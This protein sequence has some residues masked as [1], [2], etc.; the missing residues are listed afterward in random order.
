MARDLGVCGI[1]R[2]PDGPARQACGQLIALPHRI[3]QRAE[4]GLQGT[5]VFQ[6]SRHVADAHQPLSL[7]RGCHQDAVEAADRWQGS[8]AREPRPQAGRRGCGIHPDRGQI[9]PFDKRGQRRL[10]P[11]G[12]QRRGGPVQLHERLLRHACQTRAGDM[13]VS[14]RIGLTG[15]QNRQPGAGLFQGL[16][17]FGRGGRVG[18]RRGMK[19]KGFGQSPSSSVDEA[20]ASSS[21]SRCRCAM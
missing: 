2:H 12:Q 11:P 8:A 4:R 14:A 5:K 9:V 10:E 19:P 17:Q 21:L 3:G 20:A 1:R 15:G 6:L 18:R 7:A 13:P 16:G